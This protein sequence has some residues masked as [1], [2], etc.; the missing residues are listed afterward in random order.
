MKNFHIGRQTTEIQE[1]L[2]SCWTVTLEM[3][4]ALSCEMIWDHFEPVR[5]EIGPSAISAPLPLVVSLP[6][7]SHEMAGVGFEQISMLHFSEGI[8]PSPLK[9]AVVYFSLGQLYTYLQPFFL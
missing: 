7:I 8:F 5:P 9:V 1:D 3:D 6:K 4:G 2:E